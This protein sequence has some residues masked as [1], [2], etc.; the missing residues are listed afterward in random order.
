MAASGRAMIV[1][2]DHI[3]GS[4]GTLQMALRLWSVRNE[5]VQYNRWQSVF[6]ALIR[7]HGCRDEGAPP[8]ETPSQ[9]QTRIRRMYQEI[10]EEEERTRTFEE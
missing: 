10:Q 8:G 7:D 6:F 2:P 9:R 4:D 3:S 1:N 5:P